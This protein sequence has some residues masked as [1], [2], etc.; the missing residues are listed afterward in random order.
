MS[1]MKPDALTRGKKPDPTKRPFKIHLS[2]RDGTL[3][4]VKNMTIYG[5]RMTTENIGDVTCKICERYAKNKK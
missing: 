4:N 5:A 2:T 1:E 3:C